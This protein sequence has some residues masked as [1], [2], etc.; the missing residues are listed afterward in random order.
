LV[1]RIS[2]AGQNHD[3]FFIRIY[4]LVSGKKGDWKENHVNCPWHISLVD[5]HHLLPLSSRH[6]LPPS[7]WMGGPRREIQNEQDS[8]VYSYREKI[9]T[10][11]SG[12]MKT[13]HPYSLRRKKKFFL[14]TTT[15]RIRRFVRGTMWNNRAKQHN[16]YATLSSSAC[17]RWKEGNHNK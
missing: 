8:R 14:T 15:E 1:W 11:L 7:N 3:F 5:L 16:W 6:R 4:F 9:V 17:D 2:G 12:E 13:S 10:K